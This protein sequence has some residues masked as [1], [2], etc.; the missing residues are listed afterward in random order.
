VTSI[1]QACR[2]FTISFCTLRAVGLQQIGKHLEF[3]FFF[4]S[5]SIGEILFVVGFKVSP[6][7]CVDLNSIINFIEIA[8]TGR[9]LLPCISYSYSER[10]ATCIFCF[11][12]KY[13]HIHYFLI[14]HGHQD[15]VSSAHLY[16][17]HRMSKKGICLNGEIQIATLRFWWCERVVTVIRFLRLVW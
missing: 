13:R 9:I 5:S 11:L 10:V 4:S 7:S 17:N 8:E 15:N 16:I 3:I 2:C 1:I 12:D 6:L 14:V